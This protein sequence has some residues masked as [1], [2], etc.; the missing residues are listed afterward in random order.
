[1]RPADQYP[2]DHV[3]GSVQAHDASPSSPARGH[4]GRLVVGALAA[5][6]LGLVPVASADA[7]GVGLGTTAAYGVLGGSAVTNT[8]PST[9]LGD[10][11][12]A[13]GTAVS[14][15]PP[16][17]VT[18]TI[19]ANDANALQA[20][21]DLVTAYDDAAS[22][23][24]TATISQDLAGRTLVAGVYTAASSLGL[25]G[26]LTL[27]AKGDPDAVFVFQAGSALNVASSSRV[28][29]VNGAQACNVFWKVGSSATI[30]TASQFTGNVLALTSISLTT[31]A[32][33]DGR[34]LARNGAVTL[35]TN[36]IRRSTC[37]TAGDGGSG[38][39]TAP[40]S[41]AP[42]GSPTA[43]GV[44]SDDGS[45]PAPGVGGGSGSGPTTPAGAV[46]PTATT[47]GAT[48]GTKG[49]VASGTVLPGSFDVRYRFEFGTTRRYGR[50]TA[51]GR[52]SADGSPRHV[53]RALRG[54]KPCTRYHYRLVVVL[55]S[56]RR[57]VGRDRSFRTEGCAAR[58]PRRPSGFAGLPSGPGEDPGR[59]THA[60]PARPD[61]VRRPAHPMPARPAPARRPGVAG[62]L[63][64]AAAPAGGATPA[65]ASS[66]PRSPTT[67]L[68]AATSARAAPRDTSRVLARVAATRPITGARTVLPVLGTARDAVGHRWSRVLLP[69][70]PNGRSGW[71]RDR[72]TRAATTPWAV[73]I[74]R[75]TRRGVVRRLGRVVRRFAVVVGAP[76]TPTPT[77]R[78]FVEETVRL[79]PRA[80][81]GPYAVALSARSSVLQEFDGGPGQIALHGRTGL[82]GRL[83]TAVSHGC[84]RLA[85]ADVRWIASRIGPG[86]RVTVLSGTR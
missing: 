31:G 58:R 81:A 47:G 67:V 28:R 22:R 13:P 54:L 76:A 14:G 26:T 74:D 30:G 3:H 36:T 46:L 7:A 59:P 10:V 45:S 6:V 42:G 62:L 52:L 41:P 5:T 4:R 23:G 20:K 65:V 43:P 37:A 16:G 40:G 53:R 48:K 77:G 86:V 38:S 69:G 34:A 70:R 84:V 79:A 29:L 78:Y 49:G 51:T 75:R 25:S 12:V 35:D 9:I 83:G 21:A 44:G 72:G 80:Q 63:V 82:G 27:D 11:G 15:F 85:D 33:L 18:G 8:G 17:T 24:S 56:G 2:V 39:P 32:T 57:I 1:M 68:A 64:I 60:M 71:I 73:E 66:A 55:P 19:H 50:S 61:P